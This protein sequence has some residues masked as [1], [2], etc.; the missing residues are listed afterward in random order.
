MAITAANMED[1]TPK[2]RCLSGPNEGIAFDRDDPCGGQPS[3]VF[4]SVAC[5]CV[6][7]FSEAKWTGYSYHN[8]SGES[9][10]WTTGWVSTASRFAWEGASRSL[11]QIFEPVGLQAFGYEDGITV[12][13]IGNCTGSSFGCYLEEYDANGD[14]IRRFPGA[15]IYCKCPND[16]A[17]SFAPGCESMGTWEFR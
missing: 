5:D 10:F 1:C 14:Y 3:T 2:S 9:F 7:S 16:Y 6:E 8:L 11:E 12:T 13:A 15:N 4:D 17:G